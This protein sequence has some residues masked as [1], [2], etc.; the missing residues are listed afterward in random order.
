M[1][2]KKMCGVCG[3]EEAVTNCEVCGIP[4]CAMCV[5]EITIQE[6]SPTTLVRG[7]TISPVHPGE[8]K[9]KLCPK[10]LSEFELE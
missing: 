1:T 5:K 6:I 3:K 9:K 2:E 10:C 7:A 8:Q 4:L